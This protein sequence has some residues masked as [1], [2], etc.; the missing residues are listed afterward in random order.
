MSTKR[1]KNVY[2]TLGEMAADS[3]NEA[4][5]EIRRKEVSGKYTVL[6]GKRIPLEDL[7]D[8]EYIPTVLSPIEYLPRH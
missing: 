5:R 3:A 1:P 8:H 7:I 6:N 4:E 2:E